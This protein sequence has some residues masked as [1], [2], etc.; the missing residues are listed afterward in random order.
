[1][2]KICLPIPGKSRQVLYDSYCNKCNNIHGHWKYPCKKCDEG[3]IV[4][5]IMVGYGFK[6]CEICMG[7][8]YLDKNK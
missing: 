7:K 3:Y 1:M 6:L 4:I 5:P 8:G 2:N